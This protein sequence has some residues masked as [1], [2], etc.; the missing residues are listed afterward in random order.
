MPGLGHISDAWLADI[1]DQNERQS[2]F[3]WPAKLID[4]RASAIFRDGPC[5]AGLLNCD[6][7]ACNRIRA[8][9]LCLWFSSHDVK[10]TVGIDRPDSA[11]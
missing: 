2:V 8:P 9:D 6:R 1:I 3:V 10:C 5:P 4:A 11:E 7:V